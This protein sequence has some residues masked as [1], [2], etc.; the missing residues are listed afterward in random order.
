MSAVEVQLYRQKERQE[1]KDEFDYAKEM[2]RERAELCQR[3]GLKA[4]AKLSERSFLDIS[5][6]YHRVSFYESQIWAQFLPTI[7]GK[8]AGQWQNY[9]YDV[10]P[11]NVLEEIAFAESLQIFDNFEIWTPENKFKDPVVAGVVYDEIAGGRLTT[12]YLIARWGE[13]LKPFEEIEEAVNRSNISNYTKAD[14]PELV[15]QYIRGMQKKHPRWLFHFYGKTLN[16][17]HWH[18]WRRMYIVDCGVYRHYIC[19]NCNH[20]EKEK[21]Y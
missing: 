19:T 10:I 4:Q 7:Y 3:S 2:N 15:Y 9:F 8:N 6:I 12:Y 5:E 17:F 13:S 16:P 21:L 18:C 14:I 20:E 11:K 1:I